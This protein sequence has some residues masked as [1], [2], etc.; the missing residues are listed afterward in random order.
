[1]N[2]TASAIALI[3]QLIV[4]QRTMFFYASD[5]RGVRMVRTGI[6]KQYRRRIT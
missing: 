6:A 2:R 4:R 1:M 5:G 3:V